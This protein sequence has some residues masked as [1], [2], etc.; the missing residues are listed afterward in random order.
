LYCYVAGRRASHL[1]LECALQCRP[2]VALIGE[3]IAAKGTTL[4]EIVDDVGSLVASRAAAGLHYGVVLL[5]EGLLSFIPDVAAL[6]EEVNEAM[7]AELRHADTVGLYTLNEFN[8]YQERNCRQSLQSYATCTATTRG[9]SPRTRA[10]SA[11]GCPPPP[12]PSPRSSPA[13]SS[14]SCSWVGA[15]VWPESME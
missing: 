5:P 1:T 12:P 11:G 6:M 14:T 7:C 9:G 15:G 3:E 13:A 8:P 2:N 4:R 10:P